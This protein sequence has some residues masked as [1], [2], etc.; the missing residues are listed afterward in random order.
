MTASGGPNHDLLVAET[1]AFPFVAPASLRLGTLVLSRPDYVEDAPTRALS[2]SLCLRLRS[3]AMGLPLESLTQLQRRVWFDGTSQEERLL[4]LLKRVASRYLEIS[5]ARVVLRSESLEDGQRRHGRMPELA[6][7]FRWLTLRMPADLLLAAVTYGLP[8]P[9]PAHHIALQTPLLDALL[10]KPIAETHLH[11]GNAVRFDLLW[12][13]LMAQIASGHL[14][15]QLKIS[16]EVS[17][18]PWDHRGNHT[19]RATWFVGEIAAAGAL[20][21]ALGRLL[22]LEFEQRIPINWRY[23]PSQPDTD[24]QL[25]RTSLGSSARETFDEVLESA[26]SYGDAPRPSWARLQLLI[27]TLM[28]RHA[29]LASLGALRERTRLREVV[30]KDPLFELGPTHDETL[31]PEQWLTHWGLRR[32]ER[33]PDSDFT[34]LFW[35][36][37]KLRNLIYDHLTQDPGVGGLDWFQRYFN[38]LRALRRGLDPVLVEVAEK[39]ETARCNLNSLEV[40]TSPDH[41]WANNWKL[42]RSLSKPR[43]EMSAR[44][45]ELAMVL[46]FLKDRYDGATGRLHADPE[47]WGWSYARW[48]RLRINEVVALETALLAP[49]SDLSLILRGLDVASTELAIPTWPL[50]PLFRRVTT[51]AQ[52]AAELLHERHPRLK[53]PPIRRTVHAGEDYRRLSEGLRR[54]DELVA[55]GILKTGDRI[56]HGLALGD[57][58]KR[59]AVGGESVT[60]PRAER[61]MDLV[62]EY[63]QYARASVPSDHQRVEYVRNEAER[64]ARSMFGRALALPD[65]LHLRVRLHDPDELERIGFPE[66]PLISSD[67][68]ALVLFLRDPD[69]FARGLEGVEVECTPSEV[70]FLSAMQLTLRT[71]LARMEI[72][73]ESNPS[74][75]L[76]IGNFGELEDHPIFRLQ[77]LP[78]HEPV[79]GPAVL[80]SIN[81]DDPL[82]FATCLSDEYAHLYLA[83]QRRGVSSQQAIEWLD[84]LR[85]NGWNSRFSVPVHPNRHRG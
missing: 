6:A 32:V 68:D 45:C 9:L 25:E 63:E 28:T 61:L 44:G 66:S 42:L 37:Q 59:W 60:Q 19:D 13:A 29:P 71:R 65:L 73:I 12:T 50:I 10:E 57:D 69:V 85:E 35:H 38:R 83:L 39:V 4:P 56:G 52:R 7:R 74:S 26:L 27:R 11:L 24:D 14:A 40:R 17:P 20:R 31:L 80:M 54:I 77:P 81:S 21:W 82:T 53:V 79:G 64:M 49:G 70:D 16:A 43:A 18:Q 58:P 34:T 23:R 5:G 1:E 84:R 33:E 3:H 67:E 48:Y 75:N 72:T 51:V 8:S 78:G 30:G 62:W 36:Y 22:H 55:Y 2:E 46:H 76:L 47:T 41:R 15:D